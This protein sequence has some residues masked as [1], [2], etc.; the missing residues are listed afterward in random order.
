[1]LL[2]SGQLLSQTKVQGRC[3]G[4]PADLYSPGSGFRPQRPREQLQVGV[5]TGGRHWRAVGGDPH[6]PTLASDPRLRSS[7]EEAPWTSLLCGLAVCARRV[8]PGHRALIRG[9]SPAAPAPWAPGG[10]SRGA[11]AQSPPPARPG[12][13]TSRNQR[14][15]GGAWKPF[16]GASVS[17]PGLWLKGGDKPCE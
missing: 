11:C 9:R 7:G 2:A 4:T 12:P 8:R 16:S 10:P 1:M 6:Q 3:L 13:D 14:Q 15:K 17:L 5:G